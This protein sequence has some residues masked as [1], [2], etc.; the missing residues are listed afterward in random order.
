MGYVQELS[1]AGFTMSGDI[2]MGQNALE[3]IRALYGSAAG[4]FIY[5]SDWIEANWNV[6]FLDTEA[7]FDIGLVPETTETKSL[8][9]SLKRW[10]NLYANNGYFDVKMVIPNHTPSSA[11]DTG[12]AGETCYDASYF[13]ECVAANTWKRVAIASW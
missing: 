11:G 3:N 1:P 7:V 13:Y 4:I 8:G 5:G 12:V 2:K 10:L 6:K 9:A